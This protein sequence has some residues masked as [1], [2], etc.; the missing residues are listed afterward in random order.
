MYRL[1]PLFLILICVSAARGEDAPRKVTTVEGVTEYR[2]ANGA[3][4]LLFPEA[5]RPMVTVNMTV[6]VGSRHEGYGETGMAHL[7]EHMVFKGTPTFPN[8]PKALRDHG[9]N[10]NGTTNVDRTNYFET[11]PANDENLEFGIHLEADRLVNSFVKR[12]DL[13]SEMTVV[14]NEFE[15]G[16]NSPQ[17]VLMQRIH[18]AAYEW[19][20]YGK[21]TIGN[22]SDIERVPIT[23]LQ[24][25]YRKFYQPDNVVM[26]VAGKFE[27]P[28]ALALVQKYLGSIPKPTRKLD[29]TYTEEPAQDGEHNVVLRRVGA[30]G[31]V[32]V[33]YH[34]PAAAHPDYAPLSLLAGIVSQQPNG[35]LYKAL[36]ESKKATSA[37]ASAGNNHDPALFTASAQA[38]PG[39]L[40]AVRDTFLQTLENLATVPFTEDEVNRAK[41][42]NRR[43]QENLQSNSSAM[44]Q[45]LSSAS[46]LGDWR[47]LFVQRDRIQGTTAG[48]V[49]RVARTYFQRPNRTVGIFIPET[50]PQRLEIAAAPPVDTLVKNYKG[51]KVAAAGEVFD[52]S[53]EN[54]DARTKI[55]ELSGIKAGLLPKKNRGETVSMVLT[56]HFGNEESLKGQVAA[57]G[58]LPRMLMAGTTKHDRQALREE[59]D[60]LGIRITPG[61]GG[62]GGRGGRRGGPGAGGTPGQLTFSVEAKHS[63]LPQAI[64]LLGEILREPAFPAEEFGTMKRQSNQMSKMMRT[65]PAPLASNRLARALA[66]Y[67][68][69]DVRYVPTP[70]ENEKRQEAVSLDQVI[71]LYAKQLGATQA[72]LA[73]VG[74]FDP[75]PTLAQVRETLKDWKSD[76][77]IKRIDHI[78]PTNVATSKEDIVTPDKANAQ[79]VAGLAFPLKETDPEFAALR[80]G[81]FIFGGGTLSSRLGNRIRQKEGLSY[82]VTSQF[83]ASPRDPSATFTISASAKPDNIDRLEKAA[84]EELTEFLAQGPSPAELIDAQK[85]FLEA[86]KVGRTGDAAIA[87]QITTNLNLGRTFAHTSE[88]EKQIAA[89]TPDDVKA[90][91]RK[92][93]DPKKLVIIRAGDFKQ[94]R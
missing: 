17:G 35:R 65:E 13:T 20:N 38:D 11:M 90:A 12:E 67:P 42:R 40:D 1:T 45:A 6:L 86:Q 76:V 84:I 2:L 91:F 46:A 85:A 92:Y 4:V 32:G 14:R 93:I 69:D 51:G 29:D 53:P 61:M 55:V 10:F 78:A 33:A 3:R 75:E 52:P 22:R 77:P 59:L 81:N 56:L 9:S 71:A 39:Q 88:Q 26:I 68:P 15:I 18:A 62:F 66:P 80:L 28:K 31:V 83:N 74:D 30:V 24:A 48:D 87:G 7:L 23:N 72:E 79:F 36:V 82:G 50:K 64:S 34:I 25:F 70:E 54:L 16:E 19:H 49:N 41:V 58:M 44:S 60:A 27:E 37:N 57:A 63:T 21:S 89:L 73:I 8:V 5:S 47:L 94:L 43:N